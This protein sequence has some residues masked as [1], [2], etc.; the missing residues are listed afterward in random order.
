LTIAVTL[1]FLSP[2]AVQA[3]VDPEPIDFFDALCN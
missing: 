3:A 2:V 1:L